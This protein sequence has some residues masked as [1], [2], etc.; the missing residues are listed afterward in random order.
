M[1]KVRKTAQTT[2]HFFT[3]VIAHF[4]RTCADLRH[5]S[6]NFLLYKPRV[7]YWKIGLKVRK[8]IKSAQILEYG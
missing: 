4:L 5:F 8:M 1:I 3:L 2:A 6:Y 7:Y